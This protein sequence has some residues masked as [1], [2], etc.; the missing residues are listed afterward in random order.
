MSPTASTARRR[1]P[2]ALAL[3]AGLLGVAVSCVGLFTA[4][5]DFFRALLVCFNYVAALGLGCLVLL[6][7]HHL[8]GGRWGSLVERVLRA[9]VDT[10]PLVALLLVPVCFGLDDLYPWAREHVISTDPLLQKKLPYLE[11]WFFVMRQ[12]I[13]VVLVGGV[14]LLLGRWPGQASAGGLVV[15][16]LVLTFASLDWMMALEPAWYST[17]YSLLTATT[18]LVAA[19]ALVVFTVTFAAGR[20]RGSLAAKDTQDLGNL[21]LAFI[22][23]WVY[24]AYS[25]YLVMWAGNLPEEIVWYVRRT[26]TSWRWLVLA[27]IVLHVALPFLLLLSRRSK[28]SRA[29]MLAVSGLLLLMR[30]VDFHWMIDPALAPDGVHLHWLD[31]S[32][33]I[34]V[35]GL[36]LAVYLWRL[37]RR[38]ASI[39]EAADG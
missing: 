39:Q 12:A 18:Y 38:G 24:A 34:A 9:G 29:T 3:G 20:V 1:S 22:M 30:L 7:I 16:G 11:E 4:P 6:M 23:L 10:L 8:T 19:M 14:V 36:W 27:L 28:R 5:S 31:L 26:H 21:L 17:I 32:M 2:A 13:Y 25:Q 15:V 37:E 33:L 35:G